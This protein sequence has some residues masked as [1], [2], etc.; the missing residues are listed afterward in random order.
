MRTAQA[1]QLPLIQ[2]FIFVPE[3][4]SSLSFASSL[5]SLKDSRYFSETLRYCR[6]GQDELQANATANIKGIQI[7]CRAGVQHTICTGNKKLKS[8]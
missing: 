3:F 2:T 8:E 1:A 4:L 7:Y 6:F 5:D